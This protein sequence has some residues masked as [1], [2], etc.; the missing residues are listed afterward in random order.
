MKVLKDGMLVMCRTWS[1][2]MMYVMGRYRDPSTGW[3]PGSHKR[4]WEFYLGNPRIYTEKLEKDNKGNATGHKAMT[5]ISLPGLP[6][7]IPISR[8]WM[9][10]EVDAEEVALIELYERVTAKKSTP[11]PGKYGSSLN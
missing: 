3:V 11:V 2:D 10:W 9:V 7:S 1:A 8:D 4:A 6:E 5:L